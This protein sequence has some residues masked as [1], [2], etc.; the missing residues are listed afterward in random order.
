MTGEG[1]QDESEITPSQFAFFLTRTEQLKDQ[2]RVFN[3]T[4]QDFKLLNPNTQTCP[5][6]RTREDAELT[7]KIYQRVPILI[8][9]K[10]GANPWGVSFLRM[11]DMAIDSHLFKTRT[12]LETLGFHLFGNRMVKG[13]EIY[14][15][16]YEGKMFMQYDHRYADVI[17]KDNL[18]RPGQ[19]DIV[20][21][22]KHQNPIFIPIPRFWVRL[23]EIYT[24]IAINYKWLIGFKNVTSPTNERTFLKA[25]IPLAA[26]GNSIPLINSKINPNLQS[27]LVGNANSLILDFITRQ[28]MGNINLNFYLVQQLPV[29]PPEFYTPSDIIFIV[30]RVLEL[31]YTAW[32]IKAFAD[33][34]WRDADEYLRGVLREQWEENKRI[35]GGHEWEPPEW[36]EIEE[37]G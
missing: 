34:V 18:K 20:S 28:K 13:E 29:L 7:K 8:N 2:H 31:T 5:I 27:I 9:E 32:D 33:D 36:A 14:L 30:P 16:L 12:E 15:Q 24:K 22:E 4:P 3:L 6:F 11:F 26:V 23:K 10:T 25:I 35:T 21:E 19:V 17:I 1:H 37:N